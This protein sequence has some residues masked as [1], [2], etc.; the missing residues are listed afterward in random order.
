[1]KGIM[2][3]GGSG[4]RL[5]PVTHILSKQQGKLRAADVNSYHIKP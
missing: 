5:Y 4:T 2:F 1:M 3:V